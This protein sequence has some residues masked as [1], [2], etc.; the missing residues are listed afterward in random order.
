MQKYKGYLMNKKSSKIFCRLI[1][2]SSIEDLAEL[3]STFTN[4]I[5]TL[6]AIKYSNKYRLFTFGEKINDVKNI[7]Y[8]DTN[9]IEDYALYYNNES[10]VRFEFVNKLTE[11]DNFKKYKFLIVELN[12]IFKEVKVKESFK[13]INIKNYN[14]M[15][16]KLA[17]K[18][19][20][21]RVQEKVYVFDYKNNKVI[22]SFNLFGDEN[23]FAYSYI[24]NKN[25]KEHFN[26]FRYNFLYDDLEISNN[27]GNENSNDIYIKVIN[28]SKP[29]NFFMPG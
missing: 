15:I 17:L 23:L 14:T 22:F 5:K 28:L 3:A 12:D 26:F 20:E 4:I 11:F 10:E 21:K 8:F 27:I 18:S 13:L 6:Y 2:V 1:K 7:Y 29:F 19:A 16:K 24:K 25:L 9:A